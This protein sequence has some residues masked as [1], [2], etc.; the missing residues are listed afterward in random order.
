M[1]FLVFG[2]NHINNRIARNR[3]EALIASIEQYKNDKGAYPDNL[4]ALVPE[5]IDSVPLA[6]YTFMWNRFQYF[7]TNGE[8]SLW[9]VAFPPYGRPT[10]FFSSREWGYYD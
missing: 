10:Y 7:V 9:Y 3:A 4:E 6:K 1:A 5:Y 8:A 2:S